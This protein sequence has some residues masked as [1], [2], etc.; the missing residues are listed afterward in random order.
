MPIVV[1]NLL[2]TS[3]G[4]AD[5]E[6]IKEL[7]ATNAVRIEQIVS[8]GHPS[9]EGFW[10]DQPE[11]EWVVLWQGSATLSIEGEPDVKLGAGDYLLI[12]AHR[13]HRVACVSEDAIWLALHLR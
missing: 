9:P 7:L 1:D 4:P 3:T 10:Y 6:Q 5:G 2:R 11:P 12:P 13:R 8:H